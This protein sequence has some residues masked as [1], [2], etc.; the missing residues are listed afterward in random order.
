MKTTPLRSLFA[1]QPFERHWRVRLKFLAKAQKDRA[2]RSSESSASLSH[3]RPWLGFTLALASA[4]AFALNN[5]SASL[6]Y[7]G[8]SN[9]LT[10]AAV[11]FVLPT[12]A[13]VVWLRL[14]GVSMRLRPRDGWIAVALGFVTA[15]YTWAVLCAIHELPVALAILVF[16]LFPFITALILGFC[17][18]EKYRWETIAAI[19][20]GF[21]GLAMALHLR[22]SNLKIEGLA[23]AFVGAVGFAIVVTISSRVFRAG[24]AR[25]LTLCMTAVASALLSALCIARGE[26]ALPQTG[27]GWL[28]FVGAAVLFAFA[29]VAFFVAV[30]II[31]PVRVSLLSYAEPVT[32]AGLGA[33]VLGEALKPFQIAGI[34]LVIL[35]L[36]GTTVRRADRLAEE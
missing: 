18:W 35:A 14:S 10:V 1:Q 34:A 20:L 7:H 19:V 25:P 12:V 22:G 13:L 16:Y 21:V 11:R 4:V 33:I 26:F 6:A 8:G 15:I 31:G 3:S 17:G 5:I 28:G 36:V 9:P 32:T 24:D 2:D 29:I 23:L 27:S 30:S